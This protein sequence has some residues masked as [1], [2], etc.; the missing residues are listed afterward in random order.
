MGCFTDLRATTITLNNKAVSLMIEGKHAEAIDLLASG[1]EACRS[2]LKLH[3]SLDDELPDTDESLDDFMKTDDQHP[4]HHSSSSQPYFYDN[5]IAIPPH[6]HNS[7]G[8]FPLHQH[9]SATLIF[10][11]ALAHHHLGESDEP[12]TLQCALQLYECALTVIMEEGLCDTSMCFMM[13]GFQNM[14]DI[15]RRLNQLE[16][17]QECCS[18]LHTTL[19]HLVDM[20]HPSAN[21]WNVYFHNLSQLLFPVDWPAAAA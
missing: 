10:N 13:A 14:A 2:L 19:M 12:M 1:L 9:L 5:P 7:V 20:G 6:L 11:Q 4:N 21:E 17:S 3:K 18:L 16:Q 8:G 15:Y